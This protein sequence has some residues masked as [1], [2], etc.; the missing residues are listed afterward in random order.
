VATTGWKSPSSGSGTD[1]SNPGYVAASDDDRTIYTGS[2]QAFHYSTD[3]GFTTGDIPSGSTIDGIEVSIEGQSSE[4]SPGN[5]AID[6]ALTIN[7]TAVVGSIKNDIIDLNK[8]SDTTQT[9]GSS[10]DT[11]SAGLD[12][13]DIVANSNFGVMIR[14]NVN[15]QDKK[16]DHVQVRVTYTAPPLLKFFD[17]DVDID[18][19]V[20]ERKALVH[21]ADDDVDIDEGVI[22]LG[23]RH[24]YVKIIN[25]GGFIEGGAFEGFYRLGF[26][27]VVPNDDVDITEG[28]VDVLVGGGGIDYVKLI[29]T[30]VDIGE[31]LPRLRSMARFADDIEGI[32]EGVLGLRFM[33]R[34]ANDSVA[35]T[36]EP[37]ALLAMVRLV[38]DVGSITEVVNRLRSM[39][40]FI[41]EGGDITETVTRARTLARMVPDTVDIAD[42]ALRA[43]VM[44]RFIAEALDITENVVDAQDWVS[45]INEL[46]GIAEGLVIRQVSYAVPEIRTMRDV[47]FAMQNPVVTEWT[48][49]A[50]DAGIWT[51]AAMPSTAWEEIVTG[52]VPLITLKSDKAIQ[53]VTQ[54]WPLSATV[55]ADISDDPTDNDDNTRTCQAGGLFASG[56]FRVRFPKPSNKPHPKGKQTVRLRGGNTRGPKSGVHPA[57]SLS[58]FWNQNG[59]FSPIVGWETQPKADYL[60]LQVAAFPVAVESGQTLLYEW[61]YDFDEVVDVQTGDSV[62]MPSNYYE[63]WGTN[64]IP[65]SGIAAGLYM[66]IGGIRAG[67]QFDSSS[68]CVYAVDTVLKVLP[69]YVTIDKPESE[70][71]EEDDPESTYTPVPKPPT[72]WS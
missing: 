42:E 39:A 34:F 71:T 33:A 36:E 40:R 50:A 43:R 59:E 11:W 26:V 17:E 31:T 69:P 32:T 25:E 22:D 46:V 38:D 7:G 72:P 13:T 8:N 68:A 19:G 55:L 16:L 63:V 4:N 12:D 45:L 30:T 61:N 41:D 44:V 57:L 10:S 60:L 28:V 35:L 54:G 52:V 29:D 27:K 21:L 5:R 49:E 37:L 53:F 66:A 64:P 23:G 18:E 62:Q 56:N 14:T 9:V 58:V 24:A 47:T 6:V 2:G 70:Y 1:W 20:L 51:A 3:Y 48:A 67:T 15:G 65:L